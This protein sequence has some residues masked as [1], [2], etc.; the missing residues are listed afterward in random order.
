MGVFVGRITS[1]FTGREESDNEVGRSVAATDVNRDRWQV[2]WRR[3]NLEHFA[4]FYVLALLSL[5]LF[6]LL[7]A[8]LLPPGGDVGTG[9]DF[10]RNEANA[11]RDQF[12]AVG[13][14]VF[15]GTGIAVLFSTELALLDAVARVS[16]DLLK[17][18]LQVH[19]GRDADLSRLYF[20]VVWSLIGFG[21]IVL[22]VGF[23]QPLTLLVLSAALNGF[24]MFLYS[25]LLLL[26]NLRS[27]APP[28]RPSPLRIV[29]L[30]IA[31]AFFGY[32]SVLTLADQ[33]GISG[34]AG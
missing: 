8:S 4:T 15:L 11:I 32:F 17:V 6:C 7:A 30:V 13:E 22:L 29:A 23:D 20:A 27:F 26:L 34:G 31:F 21:V 33:L 10:V 24:V 19:F 1:P 28:L 12:G 3:T 14:T 5:A 18:A 2:W 9:L 16:A 25:G